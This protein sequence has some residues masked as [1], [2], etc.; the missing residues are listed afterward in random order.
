MASAAGVKLGKLKSINESR[1]NYAPQPIA[2]ARASLAAESVSTPISAGEQTLSITV[3]M[4]Y[5]I[6]Q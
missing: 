6:K 2:Y 3:N 1:G 4:T 5:E